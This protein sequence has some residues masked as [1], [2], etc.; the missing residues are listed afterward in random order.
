MPQPPAQPYVPIKPRMGVG[1][2]GTEAPRGLLWHRYEVSSQGLITN[3]RIIPPTAQ[4]QPQ[5]ERSG[6]PSLGLL[7]DVPPHSVA[8]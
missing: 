8:R 4:N 6:S 1:A 3:A 2:A 7:A 5:I